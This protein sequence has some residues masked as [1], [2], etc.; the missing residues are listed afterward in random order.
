MKFILVMLLG[1]F[2]STKSFSQESTAGYASQLALPDPALAEINNFRQYTP[3]FASSVQPTVAQ[4]S[5]LQEEGFERI[6]YIAFSSHKQAIADEDKLVKGLGLEY[7]HVPVDWERPLRSDFY[8]FADYLQRAPLKKT[9][10]HCQVNMRA[11]AFSML[12]RVIYQQVAV[13]QAKADMNTV[14][15]PNAVWRDFIFAVLAEHNISA[16]CEGC[17]WAP[18]AGS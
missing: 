12:Y 15:Q 1:V 16:Q 5:L 9:L 3:V 14:W 17:D 6:V 13:G 7:L 4:L 2:M 11:T 10:L 18:P 8:A